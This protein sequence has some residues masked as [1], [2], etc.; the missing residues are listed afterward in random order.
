ML[1]STHTK[2]LMIIETEVSAKIN[3][4]LHFLK[5]PHR[6]QNLFYSMQHLQI[7]YF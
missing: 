2:L 4:K 1:H 5:Q 6:I 7:I 3:S